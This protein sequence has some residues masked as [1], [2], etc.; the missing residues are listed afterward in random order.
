MSV[1]DITTKR[2]YLSAEERSTALEE[3]LD[4]ALQTTGGPL[5]EHLGASAKAF[6]I[7][8][9]PLRSNAALEKRFGYKIENPGQRAAEIG[10]RLM[11]S[12]GY[13]ELGLSPQEARSLAVG[14]VRTLRKEHGRETARKIGNRIFEALDRTGRRGAEESGAL[15]ESLRREGEGRVEPGDRP[16]LS[17]P[18]PIKSGQGAREVDS[19]VRKNPVES[20]SARSRR[21]DITLGSGLGALQPLAETAGKAAAGFFRF[22]R[23]DRRDRPAC[24]IL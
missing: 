5:P 23:M 20:E 24:R 15:P 14:Y 22:S 7:R 6:V 16:D 13:K 19:G 18:A 12:G 2:A 10:V 11:R 9:L 21:N 8:P 17:A 1:F 3:D 4:H